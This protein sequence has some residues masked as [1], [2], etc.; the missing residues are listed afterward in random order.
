[1]EFPKK[2]KTQ[3]NGDTTTDSPPP[4]STE[5]APLAAAT[6]APASPLASEDI[7]KIL[8]P[9]SQEQLLDLLQSAS[10]RHP[11]VLD[12]VRAVADCD[13]T[14]RKLFVRGL[15]GE[16]TTETL[17]SVFSGFGELD[18]A[19]VIM[20]KATG[21][22][23][24]Y[25][26]V[27]FR[28]VD[29]AI[30]ALKDPSKKIDGRMTVTQLAA[31]GGPGGGDVS[32]RKVFVGNVPFEISSERLLDEFLKFGE[33]E[34]GPLGF[35]KS[36]GK[37]RGFAFFVYKTEEGAR[38]SLVEPLKTIEGHQVICKLAVDNKKTKPFGTDQHQH[39]QQHPQQQM[40]QQVSMMV[41]QYGGYGGNGYGMQQQQ[42]QVPPYNNQV[43][44]AGG[45][46]YGHRY[47]NSQMA[48][49]VSGDYGARVPPNSGG[50]YPDGSQYGFPP[51]SG[52]PPQPRV[53]MAR[54]PG[55]MYQ[56]APPYY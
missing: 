48:G 46:G 1:M 45:G 16:T 7:R 30:L 14:L 20:D 17:R 15:A 22:S 13:S 39:Q 50:G 38:A 9:F 19:I 25:G 35:D 24:G 8:Q 32:L 36:S 29:G 47:G 33:V 56:G 31:A 34:E 12:A 43:P 37:S 4:Q 27:V 49:P 51:S 26:F 2:R 3:E 44:V 55:G 28:H 10:L 11:D 6:P 54:P 41:P 40:Q 21:R 23:K 42:H 18:E 5:E 53:P 52:H